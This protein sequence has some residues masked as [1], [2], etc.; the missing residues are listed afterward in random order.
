MTG[1]GRPV[2]ADHIAKPSERRRVVISAIG[3]V[4]TAAGVASFV[5]WQLALLA[6]WDTASAALVVWIWT[7]VAR[8]DADATRRVATLE[9]NS[10]V[11]SRAVVTVACIASVASVFAGIVKARQVG[12]A[13]ETV[14]TVAA[15]L[16]VALAWAATH[17][18]F[19]LRYAHRY[20]DEPDADGRGVSFPGSEQPTYLDFAYLAF[21]VGMTFQVSDTEI[22]SRSMRSLLLRHAALSYLFGTIIVGITINV[23]AGL[24]G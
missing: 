9:D 3:G 12:G 23:V 5:P 8:L 2:N 15:V 21:T 18:T 14:T 16:A 6:G 17:T 1:S 22:T 13:L 19:T 24:L 7:G 4:A 10:R 20:Y 11:A